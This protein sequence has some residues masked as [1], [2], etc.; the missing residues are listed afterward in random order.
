M[1][2]S[3]ATKLLETQEACVG[4]KTWMIEWGKKFGKTISEENHDYAEAL[5]VFNEKLLAE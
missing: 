4:L 3:P 1:M 2:A 5:K